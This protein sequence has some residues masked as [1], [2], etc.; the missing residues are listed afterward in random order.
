MDRMSR[1]S[2]LLLILLAWAGRAAADEQPKPLHQRLGLTAKQWERIEAGDT[3]SRPVK[4][5]KR[6]V[7]R[8]YFVIRATPQEMFELVT[9]YPGQLRLYSNLKR[10]RVLKRTAKDARVYYQGSFGWISLQWVSLDTF[11]NNRRG[12]SWKMVPHAKHPSKIK[13]SQGFWR[14]TPIGKQRT[15][16]QYQN[17]VELRGLSPR[18]LRFFATAN[19]PSFA[20][21]IRGEMARR[22]AVRAAQKNTEAKGSRKPASGKRPAGR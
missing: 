13:R 14:F 4:D 21:N 18:L 8:G 20:R 2:C 16:I 12:L 15:L 10:C 1:T 5:G 7:L 9:D 3:I 6:T 17:D 11:D 22:Q 19:M